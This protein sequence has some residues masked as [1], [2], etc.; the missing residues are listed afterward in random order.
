M[1]TFFF[2]SCGPIGY[3]IFNFKEYYVG[4]YILQFIN[5]VDEGAAMYLFGYCW[6]YYSGW[7]LGFDPFGI[8]IRGP[9]IVF[10][11]MFIA[12]LYQNFEILYEILTW[13]KTYN[14]P[15]IMPKFLTH[16]AFYLY[17]YF[18][19]IYLDYFS[20]N[21]LIY[22]PLDGGRAVLYILCFGTAV[23]VL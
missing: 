6:V 2:V 20:P 16:L 1:Y 23:M 4:E 8:G 15:V 9:W 12:L 22:D 3:F 21:G 10:Y 18:L 13:K 19:L 17:F 7:D 11:P 14:M 5:G